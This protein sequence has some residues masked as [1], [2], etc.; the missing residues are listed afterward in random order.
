MNKKICCIKYKNLFLYIY[1]LILF[2]I[3]FLFFL[4]NDLPTVFLDLVYIHMNYFC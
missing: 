2:V 3:F 4:F 1:I